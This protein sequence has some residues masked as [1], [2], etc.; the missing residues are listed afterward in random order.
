MPNIA[1]ILKEEILRLARKEVRNEI[2]SLKRASSQYR[3]EI[4]QLKRRVDQL[5]KQQARVSKKIL[6]KPETPEGEEGT[7][8]VRFSAKRFAQQRQKL[9]LSAQDMG[10]L[11]GVSGQS[12]YHW[13]AEKTRPRQAQLQAIAA[14]RKLGKREAKRK[15]AELATPETKEG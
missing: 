2:E 15:L 12:V 7:T 9:G 13:E 14:L 11:L 8:R 1:S 4:A 3:L 10:L 6:K 5:E